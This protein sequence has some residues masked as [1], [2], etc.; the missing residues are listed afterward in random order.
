MLRLRPQL[1]GGMGGGHQN[2]ETKTDVS[3]VRAET[4]GGRAG[5]SLKF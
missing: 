5:H 2:D 4:R 3:T 1:G